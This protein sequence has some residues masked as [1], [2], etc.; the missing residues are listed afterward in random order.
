M[1]TPER[2]AWHQA[3]IDEIQAHHDN[4]TWTLVDGPKN[5]KIIQGRWV[6]TTK[7]TA[8]G[9]KHKARFVAKGFSQTAGVDYQET[10]ASVLTQT[11]L[12]LLIHLAVTFDWPLCQKD[13]TTAYLNAHLTLPIYMFQ[14]EGF[15]APGGGAKKVCRLNKALY[16]LKQAGR[17]WQHSL[18]DTL[19]ELS[20]KQSKKE[21]CIWFKRT[22][23]YIIIIGVYVDDLV[24]TGSDNNQLERISN[25]LGKRFKMKHL[26][27]LHEFLGIRATRIQNGITLDQTTYIEQIIDQFGMADAANISTPMDATYHTTLD[28]EKEDKYPT[29]EAIGCLTYIANATRPDISFAVNNL[30]RNV[31]HPTKR[32]WNAIKRIIRYLKATKTI[33]LTFRRSDLTLEAW[34]DSDF[35]GDIE[36]RKS[37]S[38]WLL[39]IGGNTVAWKSQKQKLVALSTTEAEYIA[40]SEASKEA[41]WLRDLLQELK[42][43]ENKLTL[44]NQDNQ[45][46]IFLEK[47]HSVKQRTKHID[48]KYHFIRELVQQG[49]LTIRYCPT[50]EMTADIFTK[51]LSK[52]PFTKHRNQLMNITE[53]SHHQNIQ[54]HHRVLSEEEC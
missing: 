27:D 14:P 16:G 1:R 25:E 43:A 6:F 31:S 54:T 23:S 49:K 37:T 13:F 28:D 47:N 5:A 7:R 2:D 15:L 17:A 12:R 35:A 38:G 53:H 36:D 32:L 4:E 48:I 10:Y 42:L 33:G 52:Q 8:Q 11:S 41:I 22:S 50:Q 3:A 34:A 18:F 26:G 51:P 45:S 19:Q 30:A 20:F 21:P 29:R 39:A 9:T 44:L 24:I 46:A 40:A